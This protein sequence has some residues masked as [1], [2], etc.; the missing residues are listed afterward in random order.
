MNKTPPPGM[1]ADTLVA[2]H[3]TAADWFTR[4]RE[5]DWTSADER[6]LQDWLAADPFHR[7]VFESMG[8]TRQWLTRLQLARTAPGGER[9]SA[10]SAATSAT[11]A[12]TPAP[13]TE[14]FHRRRTWLRGPALAPAAILLGALL[15]APGWYL[16]EHTPRHSL[17]VETS[18]QET[19]Q[20]HLPDGT[21]IDVNIASRLQ[22]RYYPGRREVTLDQGEAFFHVAP[23]AARPF[24]VDAGRSRITVVGTAF[25]VHAGPPRLLVQVQEGRVSVLPDRDNPGAVALLLGAD[26]GVAIDPLTAR[27]QALRVEADG[28]GDWRRGQVRFRRAPLGEVAQEVSRYLGRPV[29]LASPALA[30]LPVSAFF[31]TATPEAFIQLL[32]DL[33]PVRVQRQPDGAWVV[34]GA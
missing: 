18:R 19:R 12:S 7:E 13:R 23:D 6:D 29:T 28:V 16:W 11:A 24:T 33:V 8:R 30:Q 25:N 21:R 4:R 9:A 10:P 2:L 32:P 22:L 20:L 3:A 31:T 27:H 26:T 1:D 14:P 17:S 15:L 5:P 34:S